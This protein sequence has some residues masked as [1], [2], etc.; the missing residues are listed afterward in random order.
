MNKTAIAGVVALVA[1]GA[2]FG[3][4]I[5][6]TH[7]D[8]AAP[9]VTTILGFVGV[10]I[11]QILGTKAT[12]EVKHDLRNGRIEALVRGALE[13][14]AAEPDNPLTLSGTQDSAPDDGKDTDHG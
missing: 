5:M 10:A 6:L 7:A 9:M 4:G 11:T 2:G 3:F 1:I 8:S 12:E 13:K 14:I